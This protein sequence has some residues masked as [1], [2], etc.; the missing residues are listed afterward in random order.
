MFQ[1]GVQWLEEEGTSGTVNNALEGL[2]LQSKSTNKKNVVHVLITSYWEH[3]QPIYLNLPLRNVPFPVLWWETVEGLKN[4]LLERHI[5]EQ[6]NVKCLQST[7]P[8]VSLFPSV[9]S[10]DD[11]SIG[12]WKLFN[13]RVHVRLIDDA[14]SHS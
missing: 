12:V 6:D 2:V 1:E 5:N 4:Q 10:V 8:A 14:I 3:F 9:Y 7:K 13:T 11:V